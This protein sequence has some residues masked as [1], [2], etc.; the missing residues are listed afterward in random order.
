VPF[1]PGGGT[2][3]TMRLLAPKLADLLGQAVVV[4][5]RPG[6]GSTTGTA[7]VAR[8]A[9]D[10]YTLVLA[11]LSSTGVAKGLYAHLPYDPVRDLTAIAPTNFVPICHSVTRRGL[12]VR[13]TAAW[14]ATLKENPGKFSYGSSGVGSTGHLASANF[15][16]LTGTEATHVPYRGPGEVFAALVAGEVQFNSDIPNLMQ[17]Y[18]LSGEA[19]TLFVATDARSPVMPN[20]PTAAEIGL[21]G[22]KAYS[23]YGIFGPAGLPTAI[24]ERLAQAIDQALGDPTIA[25][26][27]DA[28]GTPAMRGYTPERFASYVA[29]E[30]DVWVPIV[31]QSGATAE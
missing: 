8:A 12:E 31:K 20:V 14:I 6:A 7:Y 1:G 13:D 21:V 10:G 19:R 23:W 16:R 17:P 18:N 24:T 4:E 2:D 27:L 15:L 9:P 30:I 28:L 26:R 29:S 11:T 5:N 22:Y 3:I 25:I